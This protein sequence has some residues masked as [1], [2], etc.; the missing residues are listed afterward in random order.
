M[1]QPLTND[2]YILRA[3]EPEDIEAMFKIDNNTCDWGDTS[4]LTPVSRH[5]LELFVLTADP[6]PYRSGQIRM[7]GAE[8][9]SDEPVGIVDLF[10]ISGTDRHAKIGI[11]V[12][13]DRRRQG[14]ATSLLHLALNY[15]RDIL[16]LESVCAEVMTDNV[17]SVKIFEKVGFRHCGE[18]PRWI[19]R[20]GKRCGMTIFTFDLTAGSIY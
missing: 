8:R 6:D 13:P 5:S 20:K 14:V 12:D 17:A 4:V 15:C 1:D 11:A 9:E 7:I 2:R 10:D 16:N 18:L 19:L 3:I